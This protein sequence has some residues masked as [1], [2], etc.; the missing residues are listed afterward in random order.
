MVSS[1]NVLF[2]HLDRINIIT[3]RL[4]IRFELFLEL[5]RI[6]IFFPLLQSDIIDILLGKSAEPEVEVLHSQP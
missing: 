6:F 3:Q 5:K 2:Y 4:R 1:G